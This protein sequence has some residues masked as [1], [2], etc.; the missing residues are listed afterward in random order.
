PTMILTEDLEKDFHIF[1]HCEPC[2]DGTTAAG[3]CLMDLV[4]NPSSSYLGQ[5]HR[6]CLEA[7]L[8]RKKV[9]GEKRCFNMVVEGENVPLHGPCSNLHCENGGFCNA[10]NA[11]GEPICHCP[12]GYSGKNCGE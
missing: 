3:N 7:Q 6:L 12:K 5:H 2:T 8:L 4:F 1:S 11:N 10:G 9:T